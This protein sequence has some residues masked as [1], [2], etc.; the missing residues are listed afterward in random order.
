MRFGAWRHRCITD[1]CIA[2]S[3]RCC[4]YAA[5]GYWESGSRLSSSRVGLSAVWKIRIVAF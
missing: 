3:R 2:A 4:T 1:R 5:V